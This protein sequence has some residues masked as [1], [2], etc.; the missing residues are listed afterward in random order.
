MLVVICQVVAANSVDVMCDCYGS[1][2]LRS[3]LCLCRGVPLDKSGFY[4]SKSTT[5]LAERLNFKDF[6]SKKDDAANFQSGFPSLLNLLV[7]EMLKHARKCIKA[8][9]VDQFSSLVF[10]ACFLIYIYMLVC[11]IRLA[12]VLFS[13]RLGGSLLAF[14]LL[15]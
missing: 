11:T 3:L 9:Q 14:L 8:L 4:M 6:S 10:Q 13:I 7:S 12:M 1:H 2:V 15:K 5:A